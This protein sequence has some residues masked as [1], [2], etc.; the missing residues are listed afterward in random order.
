MRPVGEWNQAVVI[1]RSNHGQHWLNGEKI[2]EF[3]LATPRMDSLLAASK[4]RTIAGFANRRR[5]ESVVAAL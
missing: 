1:F 4:Y 2:V 5:G 3:E